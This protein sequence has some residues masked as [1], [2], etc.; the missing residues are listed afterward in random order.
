MSLIL[1][2]YCVV[3]FFVLCQMFPIFSNVWLNVGFELIFTLYLG[4][5]LYNQYVRPVSDGIEA[6]RAEYAPSPFEC[7]NPENK[8]DDYYYEDIPNKTI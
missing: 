1:A 4:N 3:L 8:N 7:F 5:D 6:L 2:V